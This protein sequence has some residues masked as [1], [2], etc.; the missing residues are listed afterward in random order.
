M[1]DAWVYR[2][3]T[4]IEPLYSAW[5][6]QPVTLLDP[7][8]SA[9]SY[10]PVTLSSPGVPTILKADGEEAPSWSVLR[11]GVEVPIL[12]WWAMSNGAE[13]PLVYYGDKWVPQPVRAGA[14]PVGTASYPLPT[15][16]VYYVS[17]T[18]SDSAAGTLTAPLRSLAAALAKPGPATVVMRGGTY[19]EGDLEAGTRTGWI[20]QNH[21][22]EAVWFDGTSPHAA[23]WAQSGAV[24]TTPYAIAYDRQLGK[25]SRVDFWTGHPARLVVDQVWLGNTP[26]TAVA[27]N[28]TPGAGQFSVNQTA[29]TLT[30]GSDPSGKTVRVGVRKFLMAAAGITVRGVGIRRYTQGVLEWRGAALILSDGGTAEQVTI[31]HCSIDGLAMYGPCT[32]RRSTIQDI[33]HTGAQADHA[34]GSL[35]ETSIIRRCN[36]GAWDHEPTTAGL[37]VGRTFNGC[38]IRH[39]H[40]NDIPDGSAIWFDTTVSRSRVIGNQMDGATT[41]PGKIGRSGLL[42]EVADGG[43]YGGVQYWHYVVGNRIS[44]HRHGVLCFDSGYVKIWNNCL[45][46]AVAVY[47]WQDYRQNTGAKPKEGTIEQSPWHC[48]HI[49]VVNNDVIPEAPYSTQLRGETSTD[50]QYRVPGGS[51][52]GRIHSNWFR[53]QGSGLFAYLASADGTQWSIRSTLAALESTSPTFGGPLTA[54]LSGN[55]QQSTDPGVQGIPIEP[56]VAAAAGIPADWVPDIGPIWPPLVLAT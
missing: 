54:I 25:G 28:T 38:T 52:F 36:R 45:S 40:F 2:H 48:E 16:I 9:W 51:M 1:A 42:I 46:A 24:W 27:D 30:I 47:A 26:L 11:A 35:I 39:N 3:V 5:S 4:L 21:P 10:Q 32:V 6:Y 19:Y 34:N 13:V 31:E 33:R 50:A 8:Y 22:G 15:G 53:P 43:K 7:T 18:G 23:A 14:D 55:H 29:Q 56:D 12:R 44:G 37:K 49:H 41:V 17:T 20:I